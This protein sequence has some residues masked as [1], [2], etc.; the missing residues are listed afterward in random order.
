MMKQEPH[1]SNAAVLARAQMLASSA[2]VYNPF[3]VED[4]GH[5][6]WNVVEL[7]RVIDGEDAS[8]PTLSNLL[9]HAA[10]GLRA[11][12]PN[13]VRNGPRLATEE[14]VN[15]RIR[16]VGALA[17]ELERIACQP[18]LA[19][20]GEQAAVEAVMAQARSLSVRPRDAL[21]NAI[22]QAIVAT[23]MPTDGV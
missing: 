9:Q 10:A 5:D 19:I 12:A 18:L 7:Q 16:D 11:D 1:L 6:L 20:V 21:V 4:G 17:V 14:E 2:T 8:A 22:A 23:R 13:F 3:V 15:K